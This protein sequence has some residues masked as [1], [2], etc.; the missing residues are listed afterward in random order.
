MTGD[1][2]QGFD[3]T[4]GFFNDKA[5]Y[6]AFKKRMGT[7]WGEGDLRAAL[8]QIGKYSDW[9]IKAGAE[10]FDYSE[11]AGKETAAEATGW[12]T[13]RRRYVFAYVP[14]LPGDIGLV[15]DKSAIDQKFSFA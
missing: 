4:V 15:P 7:Q 1:M 10:F 9:S 6:V 14:D 8:M 12:Q 13:P 11:K 3:I 2:S 5:R